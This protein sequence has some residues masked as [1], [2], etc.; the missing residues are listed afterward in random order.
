MA[1][2]KIW[3]GLALAGLLLAAC[4]SAVA[5]QPTATTVPSATPAL[6]TATL[7]PSPSATLALTASAT[8]A[9]AASATLPPT[10]SPA[11]SASPTATIGFD[12]LQ[13]SAVDNR[14]GGWMVTFKLPGANRAM[15]VVLGGSAYD[16]SVDA[17]YP[18]RLFCQGLSKPAYDQ[19]LD[20][21]I[22]DAQTG[23]RLYA[24]KLLIPSA[25]LVPPTPAGW[26][27]NDC[28]QRGQ[29]VSCETECRIA[30]D[31]NP[32]IVATCTDA[33]GAYF[34]V[35]TCP[36]MSLNFASCNAEQWAALKKQYQIP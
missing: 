30:P 14:P 5:P 13:V 19:S 23:E 36:D 34:S 15:K 10:A 20:L 16:C 17:Q 9:L 3:R 25:L 1:F 33:C 6:P 32:C 4:T 12:A 7:A 31:G 27:S 8:L 11:P 29:N 35:H 24:G 2:P 26:A 21:L 22:N 28:P 18:D